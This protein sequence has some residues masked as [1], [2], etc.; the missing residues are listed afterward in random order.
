MKVKKIQNNE[1]FASP[2][3]RVAHDKKHRKDSSN[4]FPINMFASSYAYERSAD[5]LAATTVRTSDINSKDNV[6]GF[7]EER[8]GEEYYVKYDKAKQ[9]LVIYNPSKVKAP[10][11]GNLIRT[12]YKADKNKYNSLFDNFYKDEISNG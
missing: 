11:T 12:F 1:E 3:R 2:E 8:D 5:E 9:A 10:K 6:V 7:I 4:E